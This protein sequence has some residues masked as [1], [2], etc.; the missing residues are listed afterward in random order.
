MRNSP[1]LTLNIFY[2]LFPWNEE[3]NEI[4]K[5]S[6]HLPK[7]LLNRVTKKILFV[8]NDKGQVHQKFRNITYNNNKNNKNK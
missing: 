7:Q 8:M 6:F 5:L 3:N 2:S 4:F 1:E